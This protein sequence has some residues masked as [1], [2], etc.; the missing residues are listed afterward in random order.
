MRPR[1]AFIAAVLASPLTASAQATDAQVRTIVNDVLAAEIGLPI[2]V[3]YQTCPIAFDGKIRIDVDIPLEARF[4]IPAASADVQIAADRIALT[5]PAVAALPVSV[6]QAFD[7]SASAGAALNA[8]D[9]RALV[10]SLVQQANALAGKYSQ[11]AASTDVNAGMANQLV[12]A[13]E[14]RLRALGDAR[15]V[16]VQLAKP[17]TVPPAMPA[18]ELC[19]GSSPTATFPAAYS[20]SQYVGR[21]AF[22]V[23][24]SAAAQTLM[25]FLRD[26]TGKVIAYREVDARLAAAVGRFAVTESPAAALQPDGRAG[27]KIIGGSEVPAGEMPF[28]VAFARKRVDGSLGN[29]CGGTLIDD[30]WIVTAAHCRINLQSKAII[31]RTDI[32]GITDADDFKHD[33][34]SVWRHIDFGKL[35]SYDSDIALVELAAPVATSAA[36]FNTAV[37]PVNTPITVVGWGATVAGGASVER[38]HA[39]TLDVVADA[40]CKLSYRNETYKVTA[41]MYC[42]NRPNKDA[43][44]GDS[45]GGSFVQPTPGQYR[46]AGIVSFGKGCALP[47]FPGVYTRLAIFRQWVDDV[48]RAADAE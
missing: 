23:A 42:A 41:N 44:Q 10:A 20:E 29:F 8:V 4:S 24:N 13:V 32:T 31:G 45:G 36:P 48:R 6:P 21:G 27:T 17:T 18:L 3:A 46:L 38:L 9:A 43:C 14:S 7:D 15:P 1:Q 16:S 39:V 35:Q 12:A 33:V 22:P 25:E 5:A 47:A 2:S 26:S 30:R 19:D 34:A 37:L 11:S 28:A 40:T